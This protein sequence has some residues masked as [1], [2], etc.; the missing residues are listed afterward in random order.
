MS[1]AATTG[2]A[3]GQVLHLIG[4]HFDLDS[5]EMVGTLV[6]WI[7]ALMLAIGLLYLLVNAWWICIPAGT[8]GYMGSGFFPGS[9]IS[10][11]F[12]MP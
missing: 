7:S 12:P 6:T 3:L 1:D 8:T 2:M 9:S 5:V 10:G 4:T 11:A